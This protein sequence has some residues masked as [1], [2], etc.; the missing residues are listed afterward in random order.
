LESSRLPL[1]ALFVG[2]ALM[3]AGVVM[4]EWN[5]RESCEATEAAAP[6]RRGL[7]LHERITEGSR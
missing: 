7:D 5:K 6:I 3:V 2:P 1:E 4:T